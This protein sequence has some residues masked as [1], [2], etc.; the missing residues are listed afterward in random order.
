MRDRICWLTATFKNVEN[1]NRFRRHQEI[2]LESQF[3]GRW[4]FISLTSITTACTAFAAIAIQLV[5]NIKFANPGGTERLITMLPLLAFCLVKQLQLH[6]SS[7]IVMQNI[8]SAHS[9][10]MAWVFL[11]A[12]TELLL[13]QISNWY[14]EFESC[15]AKRFRCPELLTCSIFS[16]RAS[17]VDQ[18]IVYHLTPLM[19]FSMVVFLSLPGFA[20]RMVGLVFSAD[21]MTSLWAL[22]CVLLGKLAHLACRYQRELS[23]REKHLLHLHITGLQAELQQLADGMVPRCF[24]RRAQSADFIADP[25]DHAT[26]LFCSFAHSAASEA[27]PMAAFALLDRVYQAFDG[28]LHHHRAVKVEHVGNDYMVVSPIFS[29]GP[30]GV[31]DG[32]GGDSDGDEDE[33]GG[34]DDPDGSCASLAQLARRMM[35]AARELLAGSGIELRAGLAAGPVTAAV[36][37]RSRRHLRVLGDTVN[38]AARMCALAGAGEARCTAAVA[39]AL[40]RAGEATRLVGALPVKG[41]GDMEVHALLPE[42]PCCR[43]PQSESSREESFDSGP[44]ALSWRPIRRLLAARRRL[45]PTR[46]RPGS[47]RLGRRRRS[48]GRPSA[49]SY[50]PRTGSGSTRATDRCWER[51]GGRRG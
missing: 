9:W 27:D 22:T 11:V 38:T 46:A 51:G 6:T 24:A 18:I 35:A 33:R 26:V 28:L 40:A 50:R 25:H 15:L 10:A 7:C 19:S 45:A 36:I 29:G 2:L 1:E 43:R 4:G 47:A 49:R 32:S 16:A 44:G 37:G 48:T 17:S 34:D 13:G 12:I 14:Q 5:E 21:K 39:A 41:K 30:A 42:D 3:L 23:S 31:D 20:V 8:R